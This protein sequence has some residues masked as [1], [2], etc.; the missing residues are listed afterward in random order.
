MFVLEMFNLIYPLWKKKKQ[1]LCIH[2]DNLFWE[3]FVIKKVIS[4]SVKQ[5]NCTLFFSFFF[6][7][8][9]TPI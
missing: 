9:F 1:L 4:F 5:A 6:L 7:N 3:F 8:I 2:I